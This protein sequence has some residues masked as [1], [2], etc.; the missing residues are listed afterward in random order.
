VVVSEAKSGKPLLGICLGMQLLLE[1]SYEYGEHK[2]LSLIKGEIRPI[3]DVVKGDLKIPHMGWN[4]LKLSQ[5]ESPIFR[6]IE[7]GQQVYF[8]HSFYATNCDDSVIATAEY[9]AHLTAAVAHKN[10]FGCQFHPEKSGKVGLNIL[11]AFCEEG[12]K[13]C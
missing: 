13:L 3:S 10:V 9:G 4:S 8:V 11:R 5:P 1:K 2:G 6:Y 7:D 12:G